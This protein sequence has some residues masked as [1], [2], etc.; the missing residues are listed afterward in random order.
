MLLRKD[1]FYDAIDGQNRIDDDK[2]NEFMRCE[3]K[4]TQHVYHVA[5]KP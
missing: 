2:W 5:G 1:E 4:Q 3:Q